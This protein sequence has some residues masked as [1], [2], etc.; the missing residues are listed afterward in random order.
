MT[1]DALFLFLVSIYCIFCRRAK[2]ISSL[3]NL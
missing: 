2:T 3:F 1:S